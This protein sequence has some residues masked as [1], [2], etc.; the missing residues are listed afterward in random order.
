MNKKNGITQE[1]LEAMGKIIVEELNQYVYPFLEQ[2]LSVNPK[3]RKNLNPAFPFPLKLRIGALDS[4]LVVEHY[5]QE[6]KSSDVLETEASWK[7]G[8]SILDFLGVDVDHLDM[9]AFPASGN[10]ENINF[11]LGDS[12]NYLCDYFY[13]FTQSPSDMFIN[14]IYNFTNLKNPIFMSNVTF[15]WTD[16]NG[17]LKIRH[18]NFLEIMPVADEGWGYHDSE[19]FEQ[20]AN[21]LLEYKVPHFDVRLHAILNNLI[22]LINLPDTKETQITKFLNE[23]PEI[24]E[25][26]FGA[27]KIY[28]EKILEWQYQK[29]RNNLK[30]DFIL[31]MMDSY[32]DILEFKLPNLKTDSIVG[33]ENRKQP[34][35]EID[36]AIAQI[37]AYE[38]WSIQ[39]INQEWLKSQYNIKILN[40]RKIIVIGHSKA[41]SAEARQKL[42]S[43]RGTTVF[44]YD[45]FIE[46]VRYQLYKVR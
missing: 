3:I 6:D 24:L 13:D 1:N 42:R 28:A 21:F 14:G 46:L 36:S 12:I 11:F 20:L 25:L 39:E 37:N 27:K 41:F 2:A 9:P 23:N 19:S 8:M 30:P 44:T 34:S 31:E 15:F 29:E 32:C 26:A 38:E 7:P 18:I 22:E 17:A 16:I 35:F 4:C 33:Q 43:T 45:E 5:G 10:I 40:P